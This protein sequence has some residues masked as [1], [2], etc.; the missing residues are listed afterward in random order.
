MSIRRV[1]VE[2]NWL[3]D[4]AL[5][6]EA[7]AQRLLQL[8]QAGTLELLLPSVCLTEAVKTLEYMLGHWREAGRTLRRHV[9]DIQRSA[10]LQV[11]ME[12]LEQAATALEDIEDK[13]E[14]RMWTSLQAI[15]QVARSL[16]FT[17][18]TLALTATLRESLTH[19]PMDAAVLATALMM[20]RTARTAFMSRDRAFR[21]PDTQEYLTHEGLAFFGSSTALLRAWGLMEEATVRTRT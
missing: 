19:S 3:L 20:N 13:A 5:E 12:R 11:Y 8:A 18:E 21:N 15:A 1:V 7:G 17:P 6:R 10:P 16:S 14:R 9:G 2:T 4:V